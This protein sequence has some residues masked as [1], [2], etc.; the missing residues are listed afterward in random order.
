MNNE[1]STKEVVNS[2]LV[3][4]TDSLTCAVKV[5]GSQRLETSKKFEASK[6][7]DTYWSDDLNDYKSCTK[8]LNE[9]MNRSDKVKKESESTLKASPIVGKLS[10]PE[11]V[12]NLKRSEKK[13]W[14]RRFA[15]E[16]LFDVCKS[17]RPENIINQRVGVVK[18][19]SVG[20]TVTGLVITDAR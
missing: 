1:I 4:N 10:S 15:R 17:N 19:S 20:S 5:E 6:V 16:T 2:V 12:P 9:S 8:Q 7:C 14:K 3:D 13:K 11:T 18:I